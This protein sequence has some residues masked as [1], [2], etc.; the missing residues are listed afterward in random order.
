MACAILVAGSVQASPAG[1]A[2]EAIRENIW[3][4][5][6]I[7]LQ[8]V[9][10]LEP[11][12]LSSNAAHQEFFFPVPRT[13]KLSDAYIDFQGAYLKGTARTISLAMLVNG[14]PMQGLRIDNDSGQLEN[15]LPVPAGPHGNGFVRLG[16]DWSFTS[17]LQVCEADSAR[18]NALTIATDTQLRYRYDLHTPPSLESAWNT[19]PHDVIL[20]LPERQLD[21]AAYDSAWRLGAALERSGRQVTVQT[22]PGTG[23]PIQVEDVPVPPALAGIP[24]FD[25]LRQSGTLTIEDDAQL[26]ALLVLQARAVVGDVTL[27]SP[28]FMD[29]IQA[30]LSALE[31]QLQ[32]DPAALAQYRAWMKQRVQPP[33]SAQAANRNVTVALLGSTSVIAVKSDAGAQA[34]GL[35][36][37]AWKGLLKT[38]GLNAILA[39]APM[40]DDRH[41][42]PLG[43]LGGDSAS[44]NVVAQG[45]WFANFP[46]GAVVANG[47][48]PSQLRIDVSAAPGASSTRPVAS[49]FWNGILLSAQRL[50]ATGHPERLLAQVPEYVLGVNNSVR[51]SFQ[52]QPVS[53]DCNEVPQGFPVDVLPTSH[54][55]LKQGGDDTTFTGVLPKMADAPDLIIPET[56]LR[57]AAATLAHVIRLAS[58]SALSPWNTRLIVAKDGEAIAPERP[59][60]SM[61]VSIVGATPRITVDQDHLQIN[62]KPT[63][64]LDVV[65]LDNL[66]AA[67][68]AKA[69]KHTGILWHALGTQADSAQPP[70]VLN[71][72]DLVVIGNTGPAVWIDSSNP[73]ASL[74]P[75]AEGS[76]FFEWR[77]YLS[78]GIP[79][80]AFILFLILL[81]MLMAH[82]ARGKR[83]SE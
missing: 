35:F 56:Y 64:W 58:A 67:E 19:L 62:G 48:I 10:L 81:T 3:I 20:T 47:R 80:G 66:S 71:R 65:G 21:R 34:A 50:Q 41:S 55:I 7:T 61:E 75:G 43:N 44:F 1:E 53:V 70:F 13:V 40:N 57:H 4:D 39:R 29:R 78:W 26:A 28:A 16:I 30:M 36:D 73:S 82:R 51:V 5:R 59:F 12:T 79:V 11:I 15:R 42:I 60:L 33:F 25:A 38:V 45:D 31:A 54:V 9:G 23:S 14:Q 83:R 37:T 46:L 2:L 24:A 69:G 18:T 49:V 76:P 77:N 17:D 27:I 68:V 52:R 22:L 74:P 8:D 32:A 72:G 6:A 63:A